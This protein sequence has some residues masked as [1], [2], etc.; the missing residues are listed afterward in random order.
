MVVVFVTVSSVCQMFPKSSWKR[1]CQK[2]RQ[3]LNFGCYLH[4]VYWSKELNVVAFNALKSGFIPWYWCS[5]WYILPINF[6]AYFLKNRFILSQF[7][8]N[9]QF[10][11]SNSDWNKPN[12]QKISSVFFTLGVNCSGLS[13]APH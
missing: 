5:R 11:F 7:I 8:C 9:A 2:S 10:L 13:L 1:W 3:Y 6:G 12:L 4:Q